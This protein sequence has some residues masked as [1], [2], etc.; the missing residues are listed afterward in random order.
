MKFILDTNAVTA[1]VKKDEI[2]LVRLQATRPADIGISVV[3]EHELRYGIACN[4]AMRLRPAVERMMEL[5]PRAGFDSEVAACAA[6]LRASL[7]TQGKP[8][9]L[10]DLFI[11]ATALAKSLT[12][13]THNTREFSRVP[14]LRVE[15]W[16]AAA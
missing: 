7:R 15:D 16:Q 3:T 6:S 5:L 2:F 4:P 8:I 10:Y 11:A 14:G 13:V 1:W 12:L 9:G